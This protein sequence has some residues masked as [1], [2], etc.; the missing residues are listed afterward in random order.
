LLRIGGF[1]ML[2]D[3]LEQIDEPP[4]FYSFIRPAKAS[5]SS[6]RVGRII[7]RRAASNGRAG[8]MV[9]AMFCYLLQCA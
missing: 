1:A 4:A 7:G 2:P 3:A 6:G 8:R 9:E 5:K